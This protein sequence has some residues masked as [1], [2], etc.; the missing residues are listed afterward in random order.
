MTFEQA[1][2]AYEMIQSGLSI[3]KTARVIGMSHTRLGQIIKSCLE[4]GK[5]SPALTFQRG[6]TPLFSL[7]TLKAAGAMRLAGH[8]WKSIGRQMGI[9]HVQIACAYRYYDR[10]ARKHA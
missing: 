10:G 7:D 6:G 8:N 2:D 5:A 1:A 9:D 3:R 4:H